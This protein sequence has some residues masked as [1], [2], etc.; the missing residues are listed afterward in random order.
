MNSTAIVA[1]NAFFTFLAVA[2]SNLISFVT[3]PLIARSLGSSEYGTWWL[4]STVAASAAMFVEGGQDVYVNLAVARQRDRAPELLAATLRLR[5]TIGVLLLLP[6]DGLMRLLG[7]DAY[8]RIT[9]L[10]LFASFVLASIANGAVSILRGLERMGGPSAVR[11]A[12]E[13]VRA[14]LLLAAIWLGARV[15]GLAGVEI[16]GDALGLLLSIYVV[17]RFVAGRGRFT[18]PVA[19]DLISGGAPFFFWS[20]IL[21][22]QPA[23]ESILLSKLASESAIGWY[24]AATKLSTVLLFPATVLGGALMPTLARLKATDHEAYRRAVIESLRVA[25]LTG[26][27]IAIG[28]YI[29]A[30]RGIGLVFGATFEPAADN[31]RVLSA[32]L[33]PVFVNM[34]LGSLLVISG[35]Q[36]AWALGKGAMVLGSAVLSYI[37][38]PYWHART[39]NGGLGAA[40]ATVASEV[41]MFAFALVLLPRGLL[42]GRAILDLGRA[43]VAG[44]AMAVVGHLLAG[45]PF[46]V[47][48]VGALLAYGAALILLGGIRAGELTRLRDTVRSAMGGA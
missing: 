7:Y 39:G 25:L 13:A 15:R 19:R 12:T 9:A 2:A 17:S 30:E 47:A 21:V 45:V 31:L 44:A 37:A 33:L 24:G 29:F 36:F 5:L 26:A 1:R 8:T 10:L 4:A 46:A 11:I 35:R 38:I 40:V 48:M 34:A 20:G 6:L 16:A 41:G 28:T 3:I 32:Y 22:L 14:A 43:L 27:P 18:L 42:D 23:L